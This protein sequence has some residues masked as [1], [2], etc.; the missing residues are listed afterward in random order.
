MAAAF[1]KNDAVKARS[2]R[3][4]KV[5]TGKFVQER[6]G[7]RGNYLDVDVGEENGGIKSFRPSQVTAA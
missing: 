5:Y 2:T 3:S 7:A 6:P 4:G 1:K